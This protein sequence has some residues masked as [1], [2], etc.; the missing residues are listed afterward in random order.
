MERQQR[1]RIERL[2]LSSLDPNSV[3]VYYFANIAI[4]VLICTLLW[5]YLMIGN[6]HLIIMML[7]ALGLLGSIN[8][9][10]KHR[11]VPRM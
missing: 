1:T 8:Y 9:V 10:W 3:A 7:L 4:V 5:L 2:V 6:Y 11:T